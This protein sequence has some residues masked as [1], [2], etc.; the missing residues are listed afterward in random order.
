MVEQSRAV[1]LEHRPGSGN[2][3]RPMIVIGLIGAL[4]TIFIAGFGVTMSIFA[5]ARRVN[6]IECACLAWLLGCGIVS[7]L[8]S[9]CGS[10][11]SGFI[12]QILVALACIALG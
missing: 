10:F 9:I 2:S 12:L 8:L 6:V 11:C 7:L 3:R 4:F 5:R 1:G